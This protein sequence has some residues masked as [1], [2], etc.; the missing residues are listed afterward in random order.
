MEAHASTDKHFITNIRINSDAYI[1]NYLYRILLQK[2][3]NST[4]S[5]NRYVLSYIDTVYV[6]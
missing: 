6:R 3:L 5:T 2:T 1:R 4:N